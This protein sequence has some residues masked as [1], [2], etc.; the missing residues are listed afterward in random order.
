[1]PLSSK[2]IPLSG[3]DPRFKDILLRG[4]RERVEI[5]CDDATQRYA[6]RNQ[7]QA[8]RVR[9]KQE[10]VQDWETLYRAKISLPRNK[11]VLLVAP[12]GSEFDTA[13]NRMS[14]GPPAEPKL[15]GSDVLDNLPLSSPNGEP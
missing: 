7:L 5:P 8:Y 12:R 14:G 9:C 3:F 4:A 11:M 6:L 1:M 13:L 10:K 15:E 2:A